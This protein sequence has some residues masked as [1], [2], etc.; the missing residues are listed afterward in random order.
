VQRVR[1]ALDKSRQELDDAAGQVETAGREQMAALTQGAREALAGITAKVTES[2]ARLG[3]LE[4]QVEEEA[5]RRIATEM[6]AGLRERVGAMK[7]ALARFAELAGQREADTGEKL[8]ELADKHA[9]VL[10]LHE[11][12]APAFDALAGLRH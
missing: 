7:D 2:R 11:Q 9:E 1:A 10:R 5:Q 4:A 8:A 3:E 12:I 6:V